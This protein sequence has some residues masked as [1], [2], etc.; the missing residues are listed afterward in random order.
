MINPI[1]TSASRLRLSLF[2]TMALAVIAI[3]ALVIYGVRYLDS[4]A[5]E[6]SETVYQSSTSNERLA[7]V[8]Q[9]AGALD[10][11]ESV[12]KRAR[13]IVAESQTY[14]Y[15]DV[16]IHDL[17]DFAKQAGVQ[18]TNFDFASGDSGDSGG[19]APAP[20]AA[21]D[22]ALDPVAEGAAGGSGLAEDGMPLPGAVEPA[23]QL[24][25]T[26]VNI[27]LDNP[28]NYRNL[29][30]FIHYIEQN[31]TKMQISSI[32]LSGA[33]ESNSDVTSDSLTIEVYIR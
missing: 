14:L 27:T 2:I 33:T 23:S 12:A 6:V 32:A 20:V 30:R 9:Q 7:G 11:Y 3:V 19:A 4:Y 28:V 10:D 5:I 26:T 16:I 15:Q 29:L 13:Q 24:K 25:S 1:T 21:P 18:I 8:R 31:L 17:H 22:P